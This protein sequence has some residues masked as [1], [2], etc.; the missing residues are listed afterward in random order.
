MR[1][2]KSGERKREK[3]NVIN[4]MCRN[5]TLTA[6]NKNCGFWFNQKFVA[7]LLSSDFPTENPRIQNR[8]FCYAQTVTAHYSE[9]LR[10][11]NEKFKT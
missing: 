9:A 4:F 5:S 10:S 8:N 1:T 6:H 11:T 3:Q 7:L 2:T